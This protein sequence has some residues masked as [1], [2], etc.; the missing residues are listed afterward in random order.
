MLTAASGFYLF[1]LNVG[2]EDLTWVI[3]L[4]LQALLATEL[5]YIVT[6]RP[7]PC[8]SSKQRNYSIEMAFKYVGDSN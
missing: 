5:S 1:C 7:L 4:V 3:R 8:C 6:P 2:S